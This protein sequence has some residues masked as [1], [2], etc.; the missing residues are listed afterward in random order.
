AGEAGE[1]LE[2][3]CARNAAPPDH[4]AHPGRVVV[5]DRVVESDGRLQISGRRIPALG[6]AL[7]QG[8]AVGGL[9]TSFA[10]LARAA[11]RNLGM[12]GE[13]LAPLAALVATLARGGRCRVV[14]AEGADEGEQI[15]ETA[16]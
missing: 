8:R 9:R 5:R 7:G 11:T 12:T 15:Q 3:G 10:V 1:H 6:L 14:V 16:V 4:H 13:G 2:L